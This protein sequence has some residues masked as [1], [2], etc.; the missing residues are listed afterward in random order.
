MFDRMQKKRQAAERTAA[1]RKIIATN[2]AGEGKLIE[3]AEKDLRELQRLR[4]TLNNEIE[5]ESQLVDD[6]RGIT[7]KYKRLLAEQ[8]REKEKLVQTVR[9]Q[10]QKILKNLKERREVLREDNAKLFTEF[11]STMN[12]NGARNEKTGTQSGNRTGSR[13][14]A[15]SKGPSLKKS[16]SLSRKSSKNRVSSTKFDPNKSR[17]SATRLPPSYI[18]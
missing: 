11:K 2:Q 14:R 13:S 15:S 17:T 4:Q 7:H 3:G 5:V 18:R 6:I 12:K 9:G 1:E 8:T 10:Q 16:Q